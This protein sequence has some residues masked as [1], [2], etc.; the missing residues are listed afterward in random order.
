MY[1]TEYVK[2]EFIAWPRIEE[3]GN[4]LGVTILQYRK[5]L[6]TMNIDLR[7][8][9]SRHFI[10]RIQISMN[11]TLPCDIKLTIRIKKI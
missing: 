2:P 6:V 8:V 10:L 1:H 9:F 11:N 4:L 3:S 7:F 5:C